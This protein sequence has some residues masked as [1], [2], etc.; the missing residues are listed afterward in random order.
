MRHF[1][2]GAHSGIRTK[3]RVHVLL[4]PV[5]SQPKT[6]Q[7]FIG[8][9]TFRNISRRTTRKHSIFRHGQMTKKTPEMA[10]N[11]ACIARGHWATADLTCNSPLYTTV[12]FVGDGKESDS[13]LQSHMYSTI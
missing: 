13:C 4:Y 10:S 12:N 7:G 11:V 5:G 6:T 1:G 8:D 2:R 3:I 9:D